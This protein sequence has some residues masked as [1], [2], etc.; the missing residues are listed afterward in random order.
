MNKTYKNVI[1]TIGNIGIIELNG[2]KLHV[3][4]ILRS[5]D[6]KTLQNK[7]KEISESLKAS[8]IEWTT[9]ENIG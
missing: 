1:E 6:K 4:S 2:G 9:P 7:A 8:K 3:S 5:T